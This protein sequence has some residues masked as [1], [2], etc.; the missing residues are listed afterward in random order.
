MLN[1][2]SAIAVKDIFLT[3][4]GSRVA[5]MDYIIVVAFPVFLVSGGCVDAHRIG[6][7][8]AGRS[9]TGSW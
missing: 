8:D 5:A 1:H 2:L 3:V 9:A 7:G 6:R 4:Y